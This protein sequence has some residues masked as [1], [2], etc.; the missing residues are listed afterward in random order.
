MI[1]EVSSSL[2]AVFMAQA[3]LKKDQPLSS[4][5]RDANGT[6]ITGLNAKRDVVKMFA[7]WELVIISQDFIDR[8]KAIFA[9]IEREEGPAWTQMLNAALDVVQGI[10]ARIEAQILAPKKSPEQGCHKRHS[11]SIDSLPQIAPPI[12]TNSIYANPPP[13]QTRSQELELLI[14]HSAQRIGQSKNPFQPSIPET[15]DVLKYV[16][17]NGITPEDVSRGTLTQYAQ[18]YMDK[19]NIGWIFRTSFERR[20]SAVIIGSPH[21]NAALIVDAIEAITRMLIRSL[22]EDIYGTVISGVPRTVRTFSKTI[23]AI[24]S[25]V[26][27]IKQDATRDSDIGE[28]EVIFARLKAGLAELLSAFQLYL[29]DQGLSAVEHRSAQNASRPGRLLYEPRAQEKVQDDLVNNNDDGNGNGIKGNNRENS[30]DMGRRSDRRKFYENDRQEA[31]QSHDRKVDARK[32]GTDDHP[33]PGQ[34]RPSQQRLGT[35]ESAIRRLFPDVMYHK[36]PA[37]RE[38]EMVR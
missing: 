32:R 30:E 4:N 35:Q 17:S 15:T 1:W 26:Q 37:R 2:F 8:R 12:K 5:S 33:T 7:F 23:Q 21:A 9:D 27:C 22:S 11:R 3:P 29:T 25:F 31:K 34:R 19:I 20:A 13:P 14:E 10:S 16:S 6:L 18:S 38:M 28:V 24:E 36:E